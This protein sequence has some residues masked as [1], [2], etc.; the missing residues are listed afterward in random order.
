MEPIGNIWIGVLYLNFVILAQFVSSVELRSLE[1]LVDK[2]YNTNRL[3]RAGIENDNVHILLDGEKP[4]LSRQE[5][6]VFLTDH[7]YGTRLNADSNAALLTLGD[8]VYG[9]LGPGKRSYSFRPKEL[10][11]KEKSLIN[12]A[13]YGSNVALSKFVPV[14]RSIESTFPITD[15]MSGESGLETQTDNFKD[16]DQEMF[17]FYNPKKRG[18]NSFHQRLFRSSVYNGDS[19]YGSR[20]SAG[21]QVATDNAAYKDLFGGSGVGKRKRSTKAIPDLT[22]QQ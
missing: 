18:N 21:N 4:L 19:G 11:E 5:R 10:S 16:V 14:N 2:S 6:S 8:S 15:D 13:G 20:I 17:E 22:A 7:G 9:I 1:H 3:K 12:G